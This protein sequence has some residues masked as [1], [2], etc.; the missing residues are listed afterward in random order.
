MAAPDM[1]ISIVNQQK[2][3]KIRPKLIEKLAEL[4]LDGEKKDTEVSLKFVSDKQIAKFNEKYLHHSGPTDVLAFPMREGNFS[5]LHRELLGDVVISTERAIAQAQMHKK[6]VA[7]ELC[8]Y[9]VHGLLHLLG[10]DDIAPAN[11][12]RM[13][14]KTGCLDEGRRHVLREGFLL[15]RGIDQTIK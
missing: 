4:V 3:L 9:V 8:L 2:A 14:K 6:G 1:D 5:Q 15:A 7:E 12:R 11:R 13:K 10:Y